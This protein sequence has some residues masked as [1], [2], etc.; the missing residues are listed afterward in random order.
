[1]AINLLGSSDARV[2]YGD[3]A[4]LGGLTSIS[5]AITFNLSALTGGRFVHQWGNLATEQCFVLFVID[6]DE[7]F[8]GFQ[9]SG[10]GLRGKKSTDANIATGTTYRVVCTWRASDQ[11]TEIWVNGTKPTLSDQAGWTATL[12]ALQNATTNVLVGHETDEAVDGCNGDYSEFAIWNRVLLDDEAAAYGKGIS[13]AT[14]APFFYAPMFNTT[15][16]KDQ[17][18]GLTGTNSSG[19]D[20]AHPPVQYKRSRQP[21]SLVFTTDIAPSP[22]AVPIVIP[23]PSVTFG[24]TISPS[25]VTIPIVIPAPVLALPTAIA[26]SPVAIPIVITTPAITMWRK[27]NSVRIEIDPTDWDADLLFYFEADFYTSNA[28]SPAKARLYNLTDSA[29]VA[30]SEI[31]VSETDPDNDIRARSSAITLPAASKEYQAQIGGEI[32][33]TYIPVWAQV[34]VDAS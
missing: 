24:Q 7:L 3:I 33:E 27:F 12:T 28:G 10:V 9:Q 15:H 22:V 13:A 26:P 30:G 8:I 18:N 25:P 4:T 2:S 11:R 29:V 19:T 31:S 32:G 34:I 1:M 20:A 6:T 17:A 23:A 21:V 14:F 16:L 5:I